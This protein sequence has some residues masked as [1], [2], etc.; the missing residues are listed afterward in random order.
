MFTF[1]S[2]LRSTPASISRKVVEALSPPPFPIFPTPYGVQ[3][4]VPSSLRSQSYPGVQSIYQG[5]HHK[6]S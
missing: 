4:V 3:F 6:E 5:S 2:A 1:P